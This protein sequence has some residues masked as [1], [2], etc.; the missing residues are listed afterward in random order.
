M[1][2]LSDLEGLEALQ[3]ATA[4]YS[5]AVYDWVGPLGQLGLLDAL[6][7]FKEAAQREIDCLKS[8]VWAVKVDG[9]TW[10][11]GK[12]AQEVLDKAQ[13]WFVGNWEAGQAK[14]MQVDAVCK[15]WNGDEIGRD[16][17]WVEVEPEGK[18]ESVWNHAQLG[19]TK[20]E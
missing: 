6:R 20:G 14:H 18:P 4:A 5:K 8:G 17:G 7:G 12:T 10:C 9:V 13:E 2:K 19:L 16:L 3:E 1:L 15:D 11:E